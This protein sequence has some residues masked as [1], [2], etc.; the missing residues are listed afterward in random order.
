MEE[1][2]KLVTD[3]CNLFMQSDIEK[4]VALTTE[5]IVYHNMPWNASYGHDSVRKLLGP[6]VNPGKCTRMEIHETIAEGNIVMNH[7]SETW[8]YNGISIVLPV[9]GVFR[10]E[11][12]KIAHW[13]DYF[14][15]KTI[16]PLIEMLYK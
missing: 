4:I 14:D 2:K 5:D 3:F 8:E 12:G 7:R 13:N 6:F 9:A 1:N 10:I 16:S 15:E 11:K